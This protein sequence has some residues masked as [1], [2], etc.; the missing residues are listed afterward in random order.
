MVTPRAGLLAI[1]FAVGCTSAT[2]P[3]TGK[4]ST[5]RTRGGS[6]AVPQA[7]PEPEPEPDDD[8]PE[9]PVDPA[10]APADDPQFRCATDDDCTQTC[11][12]GAVNSAWLRQHPNAD[13]CD[14]GC[15]WKND[16]VRCKS[17]SCVTMT[18]DGEVDPACTHVTAPRG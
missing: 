7:E 1:V 17:G 4:P 11:A 6:N 13:T 9:K 16:S 12:L 3:P 10:L 18:A 15:Y 2:P 5:V 14:D 8:A